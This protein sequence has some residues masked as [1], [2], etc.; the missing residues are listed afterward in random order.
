MDVIGRVVTVT[1][2]DEVEVPIVAGYSTDSGG[3]GVWLVAMGR[4][5]YAEPN[6]AKRFSDME[7]PAGVDLVYVC[8]TDDAEPTAVHST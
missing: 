5:A 3:M 6:H 2:K 8:K 1:G 4:V 7:V